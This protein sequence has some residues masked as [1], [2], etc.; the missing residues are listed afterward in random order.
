MSIEQWSA[1][2]GFA[3]SAAAAVCLAYVAR[4]PTGT[5]GGR[6]LL[7]ALNSWFLS[8]RW[9]QNAEQRLWRMALV[10]GALALVML[11]MLVFDPPT[12]YAR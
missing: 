3:V 7:R 10:A 8:A 12:R 2:W 11:Y 5:R 9:S 1:L 4:D 6:L